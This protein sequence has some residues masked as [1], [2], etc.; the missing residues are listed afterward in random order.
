[1]M[2]VRKFLGGLSV[3]AGLGAAYLF[4]WPVPVDPFAWNAPDDPGYAGDFAPNQGLSGLEQIAI[5]SH[6]PEDVAVDQGRVYVS[7]ADGRILRST[8]DGSG[9]ETFANTEGRPLGI[10][11]GSNHILYVADAYRG[12]LQI[13]PSGQVEVLTDQAGGLPIR[14]ADDLDVAADGVI[15]FTDASTKFG[16][17]ESGGTY[18]ASLYDLMEHG[19]HGRLLKYDPSAQKTSV[20]TNSL[21]FANGVALAEDESFLVVVETGAYRLHKYHLRG[22]KA[23]QMEPLIERLPGFPDNVTTGKDGRFWVGLISPRSK[24]L[25]ALS[26]WPQVRKIVQRLPKQLRPKA[27]SYG[28]VIAIDAQGRVVANLQDPSGAYE[29]TTGALE[30]DD[31]HLYVTSL[32]MP[33][34]GRRAWP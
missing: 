14:Y 21:N 1:M 33:A 19:G 11:F 5:G 16:A 29:M 34:V 26:E 12:L 22:A 27:K 7:V 30:T 2:R 6:G 3:L 31:G 23:G 24:A 28:H 20:L 17:K 10:E 18:I 13:L 25:D 8:S 4:F 9:F 15:Y 32:T